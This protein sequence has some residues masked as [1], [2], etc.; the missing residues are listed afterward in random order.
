MKTLGESWSSEAF[1]HDD[2]DGTCPATPIYHVESCMA[3]IGFVWM[4]LGMMRGT[5]VGLESTDIL[6]YGL[7]LVHFVLP[8]SSTL[9]FAAVELS[10]A[11]SGQTSSQQSC[12]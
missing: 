4:L 12:Q 7:C 8:A 11:F 6:C 9:L 5:R 1:V 10:H 3:S 2:P